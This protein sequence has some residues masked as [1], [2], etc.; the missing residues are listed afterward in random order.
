MKSQPLPSTILSCRRG[1]HHPRHQHPTTS[2]NEEINHRD[3]STDSRTCLCPRQEDPFTTTITAAA[4]AAADDHHREVAIESK[5]SGRDDGYQ[6]GCTQKEEGSVRVR[7]IDQCDSDDSRDARQITDALAPA[8]N[9]IL[10]ENPRRND[11]NDSS[12][13]AF[14]RDDSSVTIQKWTPNTSFTAVPHDEAMYPCSGCNEPIRWGRWRKDDDDEEEQDDDVCRGDNQNAPSNDTSDGDSR[15]ACECRYG[16][17][18]PVTRVGNDHSVHAREDCHRGTIDLRDRREGGRYHTVTGNPCRGGAKCRYPN[19]KEN[20]RHSD[21]PTPSCE[22]VLYYCSFGGVITDSSTDM[23]RDCRNSRNLLI[24]PSGKEHF[25]GWRRLSINDSWKV[26]S[27]TVPFHKN[28][29]TNFVST[30]F[31][32]TMEQTVSLA[33]A[34]NNPAISRIEVSARFMG[35]ADYPSVFRLQAVLL[36]ASGRVRQ[37]RSSRILPAPTHFWERVALFL[38]PT[39]SAHSVK[40]ILHGK[41]GLLMRGHYGSKVTDC[42]VRILGD[43]LAQ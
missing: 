43:R 30:H 29:T 23:N 25:E 11:Q 8:M 5:V 12:I 41:D 1:R 28:I 10:T 33:H 40:I 3:A 6:L 15:G 22:Q 7:H 32:S 20:D 34:T 36:D 16:G 2:N 17:A 9:H 14:D 13:L 42:S 35:H 21:G 26:E 24:N 39:P 37:K 18:P 31:W 4:A 19:T 38:E 27:S